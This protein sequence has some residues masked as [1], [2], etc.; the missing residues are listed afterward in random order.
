MFYMWK[1]QNNLAQSRNIRVYPYIGKHWDGQIIVYDVDNIVSFKQ[2][3]L[4]DLSMAHT[5]YEPCTQI[6]E[7]SNH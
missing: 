2:L 6:S 3:C 1:E 4:G 5:V 7:M